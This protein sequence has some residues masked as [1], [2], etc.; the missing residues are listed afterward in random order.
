MKI[1]SDTKR[2]VVG[3]GETGWSVVRFLNSHKMSFAVFDTRKERHGE[4]AP[5]YLAQINN[6]MPETE[7]YVGEISSSLIAEMATIDEIILSPGVSLSSPIVS[8]AHKLNKPIISDIELWRRS[9]TKP[10]IAVSGSNGKSTVVSLLNLMARNQNINSALGGNLGQPVLDI[11]MDADLYIVEVSSYQLDITSNLNADVACLLNVTPDHLERYGSFIDYYQ[12]KQKIFN[13][14]KSLVYNKNDMLTSPMISPVGKIISFSKNQPDIGEYGVLSRKDGDYI[15]YGSEL[16]VPI[17]DIGIKGIHNYTNI[18]ACLAIAQIMG[19]SMKKC[20]Q[21]VREFK[22]LPH[23]CERLNI[24]KGVVYIND[25]KATNP[26]SSCVALQSLANTIKGKVHIIIGGSN[27]GGNFTNL[28]DSI[29]HYKA[30]AYLIGEEASR[31]DNCLDSTTSRFYCAGV[32]DAVKKCAA[33]ARSGDMV[34]LSPACASFDAYQNFV[35]RGIDFAAAVD[36][37]AQEGIK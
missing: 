1:A 33:N 32:Q 16:L 23:R 5:P 29:K 35:E 7:V 12:S 21:V 22:G 36:R 3:L 34:L 10:L 27:K 26:D 4:N 11:D 14:C 31:L 2:L 15:A 28:A 19:W 18:M 30:I 6:A 8:L 17:A 25:S 24:V 13:N 9:I 37:V 20:L